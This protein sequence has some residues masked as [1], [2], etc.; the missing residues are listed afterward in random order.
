MVTGYFGQ[1]ETRDRLIAF[2]RDRN[3]KITQGVIYS[4]DKESGARNILT[5]YERHPW[6][7]AVLKKSLVKFTGSL[8]SK[9]AT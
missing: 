4:K 7:G 9:F 5:N 3:I 1:R 2:H 6:N 8:F